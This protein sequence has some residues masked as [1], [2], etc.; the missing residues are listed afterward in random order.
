MIFELIALDVHPK[1][2]NHLRSHLGAIT[3][4]DHSRLGLKNKFLENKSGRIFCVRQV[5]FIKSYQQIWGCA[6][7]PFILFI[8]Y[9]P[10]GE[11]DVI[12]LRNPTEHNS[13]R[14]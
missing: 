8:D 4:L 14:T 13:A 3:A 5:Y 10:R 2:R 7:Q 1:N 11:R 9:I 12:R 6:S